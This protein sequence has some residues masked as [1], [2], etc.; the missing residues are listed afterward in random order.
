M[1]QV[2][3]QSPVLY[4]FDF[5]WPWFAQGMELTLNPLTLQISP[6]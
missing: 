4:R 1:G 5:E 3:G 6:I 2:Q